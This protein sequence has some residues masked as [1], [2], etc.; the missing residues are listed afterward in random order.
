MKNKATNADCVIQPRRV[1]AASEIGSELLFY[2]FIFQYFFFTE[3]KIL[4]I[5]L[6]YI[7]ISIIFFVILPLSSFLPTQ[8]ESVATVDKDDVIVLSKRGCKRCQFQITMNKNTYSF[9]GF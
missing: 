8:N 1:S 2:L 4:E 7:N 9:T 5:Q 3:K 6:D